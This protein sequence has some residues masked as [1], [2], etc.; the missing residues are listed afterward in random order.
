M[1]TSDEVLA[2]TASRQ[3]CHLQSV[4]GD[5]KW[6]VWVQEGGVISRE[7]EWQEVRAPAQRQ[8]AL[9]QRLSKLQGRAAAAAASNG[10]V[11]SWSLHGLR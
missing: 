1:P 3:D 10:M 6:A 7:P 4:R 8:L 9:Q 11:T 2:A 5:L